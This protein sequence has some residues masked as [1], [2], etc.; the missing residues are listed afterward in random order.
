MLNKKTWVNKT[1]F[2]ISC[3]QE[4]F[5]KI[6]IFKCSQGACFQRSY[7]V[8]FYM[9]QKT[10]GSIYMCYFSEFV[11]FRT[12]HTSRVVLNLL[13][14]IVIFFFLCPTVLHTQQK[15]PKGRM[16]SKC[17][18]KNI[19]QSLKTDRKSIKHLRDLF[20]SQLEF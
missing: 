19:L 3:S 18:L 20:Q 14:Q 12:W 8:E 17:V 7:G 13:C 6:M 16:T 1:I 5:F 15:F 10:N 11:F 9:K 2:A 4:M